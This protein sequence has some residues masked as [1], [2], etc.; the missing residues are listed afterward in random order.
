MECLYPALLSPAEV[1]EHFH[2]SKTK[3]FVGTYRF[4]WYS[5]LLERTPRSARPHLADALAERS[6][7]KD[8][9][10]WN[11]EL[12][13][14]TAKVIAGALDAV[15]PC[16]DVA[17]VARWLEMGIDDYGCCA[18]R[19][20]N[21]KD[22][23]EWLEQNPG[24][25]KA[26]IE[27][28]FSQVHASPQH[29]VYRYWNCEEILYRAKTPRDW[30]AWLLE[31][32]SKVGFPPL[33]EYCFL[34][35]ASAAIRP[36]PDYDISLDHV[37]V[38][39][40]ANRHRYPQLEKL[41]EQAW[42]SHPDASM[43]D[44]Y[45]RKRSEE[46]QRSSMHSQRRSHLIG[47]LSDIE[48][49]RAPQSVMR[50]LALAYRRPFGVTGGDTPEER[51]RE[52]LVGNSD[53]AA[54]AIN[55]LEATLSRADVP[56]HTQILSADFGYQ[57]DE[58][59]QPCLLGAEL[60]FA[61]D[62]A[63]VHGWSDDLVQSLVAF[64]LTDYRHEA[65]EWCSPLFQQRPKI[66]SEVL[67]AYASQCLL[68][69]YDSSIGLWLLVREQPLSELARLVIRPLL[70]DFPTRARPLQLRQLNSELLPAALRHLHA[71]ELKAIV[72]ERLAMDC[73]DSG[74]RIAWLVVGLRF[75]AHQRS[76]QL[77]QLVNNSRA[78]TIRLRDTVHL[79]NQYASTSPLR[80]VALGRLIEML[81]PVNTPDLPA[82]TVWTGSREK[83]RDLV[84][85]LVN[86]LATLDD[87]DAAEELSRLGVG[88]G[89]NP[90]LFAGE[91][92]V[93]CEC[94]GLSCV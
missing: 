44:R 46:V 70:R 55:G 13:E 60:A 64:R 17:R 82:G 73:L 83:V 12:P 51:V 3:N 4:F 62:P 41:L 39:V 74:Q 42:S 61:R 89:V 63:A 79:Q 1:M 72:T 27:N 58:L 22:I 7:S 11:Y 29:G 36:S 19:E 33:V 69:R 15:S 59:Q 6:L 53:E 87:T 32:A 88:A 21:S 40:A 2:Y 78:R 47:Q 8:E 37:E 14:L 16:I 86:Q 5:S 54:R 43:G 20:E 80:A 92:A 18:L 34:Q 26:L 66:I 23:R 10:H 71:D 57:H 68:R 84:R 48:L 49:G 28:A 38:W 24:C 94:R 35:A 67:I 93:L 65:V 31:H 9:L 75:A 85:G 56:L 50:E 30:F 91:D 77:S 25:Q 45:R 81:A 90:R 52:L 76:R